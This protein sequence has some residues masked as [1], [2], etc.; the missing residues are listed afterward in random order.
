LGRSLKPAKTSDSREVRYRAEIDGLRAI[1]VMLV[2]G[3]HARVGLVPSSAAQWIGK[4]VSNS[5]AFSLLR[6]PQGGFIGVDIFFVISGFLISG[7]LLREQATNTFS[8]VKFYERRV[9]RIFP[10]LIAILLFVFVVGYFAATPPEMVN[11]A[12]STLS[13]TFSV[14]NI[15]FWKNSGYFEALSASKPLLHTWSLA[16]EEQFYL[17]FPV[18]LLLVHRFLGK[19]LKATVA[20]LAI[21]SFVASV[22][23]TYV[24][25]TAAFYLPQT[26]AWEL[27]MGTMVALGIIRPPSSQLSRNLVAFAGL[28]LILFAATRYTD[29]IRFPGA[30]ALVPCL[31]AACIIVAD[32]TGHSL[33]GRLLSTRPFV[34]VGLISYSLYLW[35]WPLLL[36]DRYEYFPGIHL[37]KPWLLLVMLIAAT[38]SWRFVEQPFRVGPLKLPRP[39]L[40][41]TSA[42]TVVLISAASI[43]AIASHGFPSRFTEEEL[44]LAYYP[45]TGPTAAQWG[46]G[47]FA[48][49]DLASVHPSCF[50]ESATQP[51]YLLF[52]DSHAAHLWYGL[53]T[54]FPDI[55]FLEA[56]ASSCR[57][58]LLSIRSSQDAFCRRLVNTVLHEFLPNHHVEAVILSD[59]WNGN[60]IEPLGDTIA[61][62]H[63]INV[64][65]YVV[66]PMVFYDQPLPNLLIRV[67]RTGHTTILSR[68]LVRSDAA[69]QSFDNA[70]AET[71]L[72]NG[73]AR[74]LSLHNLLCREAVCAVYGSP[75][76]PLQF[77]ESHLTNEG[78]LLVAQRLK[79]SRELP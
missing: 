51:N 57:P 11:L 9:R 50:A 17:F 54:V 67:I 77:D 75:G 18:F 36:I 38:L 48:S 59:A 1:A 12:K 6:G 37:A 53:S 16:V 45:Q 10:A 28:G 70:L 71:A 2:I 4:H 40:F 47:C 69:Y 8:I 32:T 21:A 5:L 49:V 15:Y 3:F 65:V 44:R 42:V 62:L 39:Q 43:W 30:H 14:A 79:D 19:Y 66:G 13:A 72:K 20:L 61:Y 55:H 33:V 74:Y 23:G 68:H 41:A 29:T 76:I 22:I 58:L 7:I 60:D 31:G 35:H 34:F 25:P 73:A 46:N 56:T 64:R 52:G 24:N 63:S 27:L 26:R 78:S